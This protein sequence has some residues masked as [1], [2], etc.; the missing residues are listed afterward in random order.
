M[1]FIIWSKKQKAKTKKTKHKQTNKQ[2]LHKLNS[3]KMLKVFMSTYL[4]KLTTKQIYV[5]LNQ[6][7]IIY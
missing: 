1:N 2:T 4:N 6:F 3:L 5:D 7:Q